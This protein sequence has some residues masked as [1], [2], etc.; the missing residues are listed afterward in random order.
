[1]HSESL[2]KISFAS[3]YVLRG[4]FH[5]LVDALPNVFHIVPVCDNSVFCVVIKGQ[6]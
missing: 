5:L 2:Q 4:D 1:M 3:T 6:N